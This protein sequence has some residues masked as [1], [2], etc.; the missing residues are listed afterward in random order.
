MILFTAQQLHELSNILNTK[1]F[2]NEY[3]KKAV[4][5]FNIDNG[6]TSVSGKTDTLPRKPFVKLLSY[7]PIDIIS[8]ADREN[9]NTREPQ[10]GEAVTS[11][12][13]NKSQLQ[14][15]SSYIHNIKSPKAHIQIS[16]GNAYITIA[17]KNIGYCIYK[18]CT[19]SDI[20]TR[21]SIY[22]DVVL[23]ANVLQA[24]EYIVNL[25]EYNITISASPTI[26]H[27]AKILSRVIDYGMQYPDI[28]KTVF[29]IKNNKMER[30]VNASPDDAYIKPINNFLKRHRKNIVYICNDHRILIESGSIKMFILTGRKKN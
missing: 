14:K 3:S 28:P 19:S 6:H 5:T 9:H 17:G 7:D 18:K 26:Q 21:R 30:I 16:N 15:L 29:N 12:K 25:F 1:V 2:S 10:T 22:P 24:E 8:A 11:F 23:C 20:F 27:D 4:S 13:I